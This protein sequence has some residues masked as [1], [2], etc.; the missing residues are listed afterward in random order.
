MCPTVDHNAASNGQVR[1][2]LASDADVVSLQEMMS[3]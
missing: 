3:A 2:D 1:L